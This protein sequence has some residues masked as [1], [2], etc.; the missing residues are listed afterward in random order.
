MTPYSPLVA[1]RVCRM[2]SDNT[3][4]YETDKFAIGLYDNGK[5]NDM[6]IIQRI[7]EISEKK[8]ITMAQ[9]SLAWILSKKYV[10]CPVIGCTKIKQLE[11]LV[12]AVKIKL[13]DDEIKYLEELY[14]P[15]KVAGPFTKED[16]INMSKILNK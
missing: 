3:K 11:E 2:W 16:T 14:T 15:H 7:K 12:G 10:S 8:K 1:G 4:R 6:L 9:V 13:S 5:K